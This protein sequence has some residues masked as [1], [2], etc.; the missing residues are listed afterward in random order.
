[1]SAERIQSVLVVTPC[2]ARKAY[3]PPNLPTYDDLTSSDRRAD[4]FKRLA[5]QQ[6]PAREMY[7]GQHHRSILDSIDRLR[8]ELPG[9]L[10]QLAIVSAGYG[11]LDET[12]PIVPYDATFNGVAKKEA[13]SHSHQLGIRRNLEERLSVVD[14]GLF[15]L[16]NTY[17]EAIEAPIVRA[18]M[19]VYFRARGRFQES[20]RAISVPAGRA[21]ARLLG[22]A[23]RIVGA[24]V[25]QRFVDRV[26][27]VG[28]AGAVD[29]LPHDGSELST[30]PKK[31]D[32]SLIG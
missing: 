26:L 7:I 28:W 31:Q 13:L 21:E 8:H 9:T 18:P 29:R 1:M 12:T 11:L 20:D 5:I 23:P 30:R 19:E 16:G 3:R 14:V 32:G 6:L 27:Q 15:V 4:A 10:F 25:F 2:S 24:V 22:V 17:L